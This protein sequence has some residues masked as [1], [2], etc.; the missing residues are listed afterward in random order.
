MTKHSWTEEQKHFYTLPIEE[1]IV[2]FWS[3]VDR[4]GDCWEWQGKRNERGYGVFYSLFGDNAAYRIAYRLIKG[5]IGAGMRLLHSCDNPPC[6]N[7]SHLSEGTH[8]E[9]MLDKISK[10]RQW[11]GGNRKKLSMRPVPEPSESE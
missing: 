1:K 9:N 2:L 4:S 11:R 3:R 7:P 8:L 6:C 10:G 5:D